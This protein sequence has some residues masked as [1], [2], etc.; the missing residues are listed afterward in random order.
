MFIAGI[1]TLV[2]SKPIACK[3]IDSESPPNPPSA[4][5]VAI[6]WLFLELRSLLGL[7]ENE[8]YKDNLSEILP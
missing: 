2:L 8:E 3:S 5:N 7:C 6:V 1:F 4:F